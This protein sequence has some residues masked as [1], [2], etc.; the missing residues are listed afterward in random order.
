MN[1]DERRKYVFAQ[2]NSLPNAFQYVE[3]TN[4]IKSLEQENEKLNHYKLLYQKVKDRND[5]AIEFVEWYINDNKDFYKNKNI[6][7]TLSET[8]GLLEILKGNNETK[9]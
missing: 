2:L 7:L 4:Y 3:V 5:K 1:R 9:E 6:G 8:D